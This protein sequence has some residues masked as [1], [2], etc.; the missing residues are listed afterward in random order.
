[1]TGLFSPLTVRNVTLRNRIVLPPMANN[2]SDDTGAVTGAHIAHDVRRAEAVGVGRSG[3]SLCLSLPDYR[4]DVTLTAPR[5]A[6]DNG[7]APPHTLEG[8]SDR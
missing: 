3:V 2:M 7:S 1:M 5:A 8:L 4:Q 6:H